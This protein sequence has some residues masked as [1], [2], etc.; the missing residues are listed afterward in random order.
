M[1]NA[2]NLLT[3]AKA[4]GK[5]L[6]QFKA[7]AIGDGTINDLIGTAKVDQNPGTVTAVPNGQVN[8]ELMNLL[9][10]GVQFAYL[11]SG[12][13]FGVDVGDSFQTAVDNASA[14]G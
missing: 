13:T 2:T 12:S 4:A 10:E 9:D 5:T 7:T 3:T 14:A 6:A 11:N 1:G 8:A